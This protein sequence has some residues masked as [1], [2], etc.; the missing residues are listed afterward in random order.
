M[1]IATW[2]IN[3]VKARLDTATAWIKDAGPD[4]LCMQEIKSEDLS[5]PSEIFEELGYNVAVHGQKGFNGVAILSKLPLEDV[6]RGLPGDDTDDHARFI[7]AVVSVPSGALRIVSLYL[8]NGNPLGTEKFAYKLAWM[9]RLE[10]Y[11]RARLADEEAFVLAGDFNVIPEPID[12]RFP[13]NWRDDALFQPET[14]AAYR[15]LLNLGLTDAFRVCEAGPDH[16]SFWDYQAGA[17]QKNNG[18]RIDHM[19]LS[20]QAA[21]RLVDAAIDKRPRGWEKPSDHVPVVIDLTV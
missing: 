1:K 14:R 21:D 6:S 17:W 8:P 12:A 4:V 11:A 5:F 16:Y 3:G 13:D 19:L 10:A 9:A 15:R 7:E 20:P 2:N 18:I